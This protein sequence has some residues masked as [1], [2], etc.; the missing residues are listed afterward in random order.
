MGHRSVEVF[1][2]NNIEMDW[3]LK[4]TGPNS[5]DTA[6]D[7]FVW[8]TGL[9]FGCSKEQIVQFCSG[10]EILPNR[11]TLLVAFQERGMGESFV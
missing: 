8:L 7:G 4:H 3:V 2:S 11:L 1:K 9:H 6:N 5:P 10:L